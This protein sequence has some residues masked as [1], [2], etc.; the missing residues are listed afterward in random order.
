MQ[1]ILVILIFICLNFSI[2]CRT[3]NNEYITVALPE[4]FSSF[5]TLTSTASDAAAERVRNLMF[6]SLVRKNE[7]FEYVGELAKEIQPS[8]EGKVITFILREDVKFNNGKEFTSA[9]V[10]YTFDEL[11]KSNGYKSGAFFDTVDDKRVRHINSIE[12]PDSKTVVFILS[13][14]SLQNQLLSNLVAIPII[15]EGTFEQQKNQPVGSGAFR[16]VNFDQSQNIVELAAN[17]E[18]WDGAP[19]VQKIRVKTVTDANSLQAELQS[20]GVDIAPLPTNLSPDTLKSLGNSPSLK[21]EQFNGSNIQYLQFNTQSTP[22]NNIKLR[23]AI[24]YGIDRE[25]IINELLFGQ[26]T[27]AHSILPIDSWA[28]SAG[29]KYIY[30][31]AKAKQ[32]VQESGYKGEPIKFKFASGGAATNQYAQVIQNSLVQI[33]LNVEIEP[34]ERPTFLTQL[35]IGQYQMSTGIWVGG[36]QD[37][38]F[39][40]DL[41]TTKKIPNEKAKVSCCN[42]SRYSN[43]EVDKLI[44]QAFNSTNREQAKELYFK[45]QEIISNEV[46]MFPLW[47][48]ANMV[49]S[50]KRIDNIKISP[51]GDWGFIKDITADGK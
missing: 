15:P 9:D 32:L 18:Y 25:K 19:K 3:K 23:Q 17:P 16:F 38:I 12:T 36:N 4:K 7:K 43:P 24:A 40:N 39:L 8:Q 13:R 6:N 42:R 14:A 28:Y 48:P 1:K 51:S 50:N 33:G 26:A 29:T 21:V 44:E 2:S 30:D 41:F 35:G 27:I 10:K 11:F 49:V 34:L 37:P 46:P 31:L 5:D 20:G 47:Y 22:L 45:A